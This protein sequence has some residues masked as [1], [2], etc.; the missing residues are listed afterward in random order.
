M[1]NPYDVVLERLGV[2][3]E[4]LSDIGYDRLRALA[5]DPDGAAAGRLKSEERALVSARR[6]IAKARQTLSGISTTDD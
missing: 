3:E 2:I 1:S 5:R 6:A 4:E